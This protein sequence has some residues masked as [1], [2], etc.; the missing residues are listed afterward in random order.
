MD[1]SGG[2]VVVVLTFASALC[3]TALT[4]AGSV[5]LSLSSSNSNFLYLKLEIHSSSYYDVQ[6]V[7]QRATCSIMMP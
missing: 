5:V 6:V 2:S 3:S 4:Q 7:Q 1:G